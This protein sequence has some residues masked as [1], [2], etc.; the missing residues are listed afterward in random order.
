[1]IQMRLDQITTEQVQRLKQRLQHR[2]PKTVNNAL[3][4]LQTLLKKAVEW[5][6]IEQMPCVIRWVR[7]SKPSVEFYDF[8]E[9]E[10]FVEGARGLD[11]NTYLI[12]LLG[13]DAGLR[14]GEIIGLEERDVDFGKRQ[15]CVPRSDWRGNVTVPKGG[16][17]RYVPMSARLVAAL[18][19][20]RHLRSNRVLCRADS[21]GLTQWMV[22][23]HVERAARKGNVPMKG[24]HHLRHTFCSHLA[25]AGTPARVIQEVAGHQDIRTTQR[26]MHLS[27][28]AVE[29]AMRWIDALHPHRHGNIVATREESV[30]N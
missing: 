3:T 15:L 14:L 18:K 7:T 11:A 29:G 22:R 5:E 25:M 12:A 10:R 16:R 2:A 28:A 24:V 30:R 19:E 26:Y 9:Y 13:G 27:P 4:V 1:M 20:H 6:V 17:L 8:P 23:D 21:S